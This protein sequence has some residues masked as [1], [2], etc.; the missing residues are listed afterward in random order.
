M[1]HKRLHSIS[2]KGKFA[3]TA[4][5][6]GTHYCYLPPKKKAPASVTSTGEGKAEQNVR[7]V[8][9]SHDIKETEGLQA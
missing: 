7:P 8:A 3:R 4:G 1:K 5:F 9:A 6:I 2:G